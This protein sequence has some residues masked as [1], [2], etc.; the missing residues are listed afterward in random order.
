MV[1][2]T[3]GIKKIPII[4]DFNYFFLKPQLLDEIDRRLIY[5][6]ASCMI[7]RV[8]LLDSYRLADFSR[9]FFVFTQPIKTSR[10]TAENVT[11]GYH[12]YLSF[13]LKGQ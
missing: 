3:D 2:T 6:E 12:L 4:L 1:G 10:H 11:P 5:V 8:G 7:S 9:G 13:S